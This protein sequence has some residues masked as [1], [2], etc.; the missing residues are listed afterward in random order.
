[1]RLLPY[2]LL[3]LFSLCAP[4]PAVAQSWMTPALPAPQREVRAVWLTTLWGLDWPRTKAVNDSRRR[5]QQDELLHTLDVLQQAGVNTVMLQTRV[6][7]TWL[8]PTKATA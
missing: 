8:S 2:I 3:C 7:S 4:R 5:Q 6:R 1:M